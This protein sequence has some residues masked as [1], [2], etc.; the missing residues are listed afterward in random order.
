MVVHADKLTFDIENTATK[1]FVQAEVSFLEA[2]V[3]IQIN[4]NES[5]FP[6]HKV[7]LF[8]FMSIAVNFV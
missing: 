2:T 5:Q 4:D 8:K 1:S 7:P 6:R 3:R